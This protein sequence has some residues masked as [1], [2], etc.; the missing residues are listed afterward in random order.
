IGDPELLT[1]APSWETWQY[2]GSKVDF[3][4]GG[5]ES[6]SVQMDFGQTA[7]IA[8]VTPDHFDKAWAFYKEKG[9]LDPVAGVSGSSY[10]P[11][12]QGGRQG[13]QTIIK[14][15]ND[16]NAYSFA[17]PKSDAL[18]ARAFTVHSLRYQL[19]GF[20]YRP[21]GAESTCILLAYRPNNEFVSVL[22]DRVVKE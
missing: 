22:K 5:G 1:P 21:K 4:V 19:V 14:L 8:L 12:S 17:G 7:R 18:T 10:V 9:Q 16:V 15:R 13:H 2:P 3:S 6:S 20:V 11:W